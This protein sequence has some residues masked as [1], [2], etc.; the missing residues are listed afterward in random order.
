MKILVI[1]GSPRKK[2]TSAVLAEQFIAGAESAGHT[3]VR[4]DAALKNV[5]PCIACSYCK[6][7]ESE[8]ALKDDMANLIPDL[9]AAEM[10]VFVTPLYYS[11]MSAQLKAVIDRFYSINSILRA[12]PKQ[13][14]LFGRWKHWKPISGRYSDT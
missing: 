3:V 9:V 11:G 5:A 12:T 13:A 4:F 10:V 6:K 1:T 8:C 7:H 14:M 2:G